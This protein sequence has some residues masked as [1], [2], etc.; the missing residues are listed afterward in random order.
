VEGVSEGG[1]AAVVAPEL[2]GC[3]LLKRHDRNIQDNCFNKQPK[4]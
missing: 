2:I 4:D 1:V 3:L